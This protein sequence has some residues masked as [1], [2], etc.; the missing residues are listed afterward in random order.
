MRYSYYDIQVIL[1]LKRVLPEVTP[2]KLAHITGVHSLPAID[3]R[4]LASKMTSSLDAEKYVLISILCI[5]L[6]FID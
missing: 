5:Y 4:A 1:L 2:E 6:N 3:F